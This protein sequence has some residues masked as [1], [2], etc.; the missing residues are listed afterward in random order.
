[1]TQKLFLFNTF[2]DLITIT[3]EFCGVRLRFFFII[4]IIISCCTTHESDLQQPYIHR[5]IL[6]IELRKCY[7]N[8]II[9]S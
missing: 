3:R 4:F 8:E 5:V 7:S 9:W 6:G 2:Y 1:M